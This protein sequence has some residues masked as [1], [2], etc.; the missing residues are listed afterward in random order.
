MKKINISLCFLLLLFLGSGCDLFNGGG[1]QTGTL[2]YRATTWNAE[3]PDA[4]P[5]ASRD[6]LATD[7]LKLIDVIQYL[8][9][10]EVTTD[11]IDSGVTRAEDVNWT[12]IYQSTEEMLI[13]HRDFTVELP[14]GDYKGYRAIQGNRFYWVCISGNDT[15][16]IPSLNDNSLAPDSLITGHIDD[17]GFYEINDDGIFVKI[18]DEKLGV[19]EIRPAE[20][21][22]VTVRMNLMAL[23]IDS[24]A[25]A[26]DST[27]NFLD[28]LLPEGISTMSDFIIE[29]EE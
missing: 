8:A 24:L 29:Y 15:I 7:T 25:F 10:M 6:T 17:K 4:M 27:Y 22:K 14:V 20:F 11:E 1:S 3:F 5:K 23:V 18:N 21:T 26:Q 16:N 28:W 12:V 9:K 13:T 2:R 19:F